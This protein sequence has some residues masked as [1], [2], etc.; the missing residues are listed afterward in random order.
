MDTEERVRCTSKNRIS[1]FRSIGNIIRLGHAKRSVKSS[2]SV[3]KFVDYFDG[4]SILYSSE[5]REEERGVAGASAG[6]AGVGG[7][8]SED[9]GQMRSKESVEALVAGVFIG[10]S[11]IKASYVQLQ[12]A[13]TPYDPETIQTADRAVVMELK[14]ISVLKRAY[15]SKN[16][17]DVGYGGHHLHQD[18]RLAAEIHELKH[19]ATT[20]EVTSKKM[21]KE[22]KQKEEEMVNLQNELRDLRKKN[23]SLRVQAHTHSETFNATCI[24]TLQDLH[25]SMLNPTHFLS[26]LRYAVKS[27]KKFVNIMI[28]MMEASGWSLVEAAAVIEP[29]MHCNNPTTDN[30]TSFIF[31]S[32]VSRIMF[33]DFHTPNFGL[34]NSNNGNIGKSNKSPPPPLDRQKFFDDFVPLKS[35][36]RPKTIDQ[37][38]KNFQ[39]TKFRAIV[40]AKML[41]SFTQQG[42]ISPDFFSSFAEM[43]RRVWLLQ[44]LFFSFNPGEN[45]KVF[46]V[47]R[48]S[49]YSQVYMECVNT[50]EDTRGW[51]PSVGFTVFPG[52]EIQRTVIQCMVYLSRKEEDQRT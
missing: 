29:D 34:S 46:Q 14:N 28:H 16:S 52:F 33:S 8:N 2:I 9:Q 30:G 19:L 12:I 25:I 24:L 45:A 41:A 36:K 15:L 17:A 50:P 1:I 22:A 49:R 20:F 3:G 23:S 6:G 11:A 5:L 10:V 4:G 35:L 31:L 21:V 40:H 37:N 44:R 43:T 13:Q 42:P 47:R 26:F 51:V 32:Y 48:G 7:E 27:I 38:L 18:S 39:K